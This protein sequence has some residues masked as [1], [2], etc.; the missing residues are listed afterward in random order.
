[1]PV[2]PLLGPGDLE[3]HVAEVVFIA[4]DVGQEDVPTRGNGSS[5]RPIE[6]PPTGLGDRHAG[7]H[8]AE[9]RPADRGHRGGAVGFEDVAD[10]PD[11][12]REGRRIGQDRGD[13]PLG[14][15]PVADLA[16]AR[17]PDRPD[18][19]DGERRHVVVQHEGLAVLGHDPVDPLGV[20]ARAEHGR[21]QGLGLAL[22][23][24]WPSRGRWGRRET[25][26][27]IGR[28]S[29]GPRPSDRWPSRISSRTTFSSTAW[30]ADLTWSGVDQARAV[31]RG[32]TRRRPA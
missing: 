12:V 11:R 23:G 10:H 22:A 1:M 20:G 7:V 19:A 2:T 5:T 16:A 4:D 21:D 29:R 9:G 15:G 25:S 30:N 14:Q 26:Q 13:R 28:R 18:L 17:S 3:V 24:R 31:G 8:Q 27:E 32:K 6:I